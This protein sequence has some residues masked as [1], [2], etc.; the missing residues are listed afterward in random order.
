MRA[1]YGKHLEQNGYSPPP[2]RA[3]AA[4][5]RAFR[6]RIPLR[7]RKALW[8]I[9]GSSPGNLMKTLA[10]MFLRSSPGSLRKTLPG[11]GGSGEA[12]INFPSLA[13]HHGVNPG[14]SLFVL[15]MNLNLQ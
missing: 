15:N 11:V 13:Y 3:A 8:G 10:T 5:R 12:T 7:L 14:L 9:S 6:S 2:P 4:A 1:L